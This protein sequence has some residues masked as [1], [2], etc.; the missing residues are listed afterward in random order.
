[1]TV[2]KTMQEIRAEF[3]AC[4]QRTESVASFR[5]RPAQQ[6]SFLPGQFVHVIFD[7]KDQTNRTLNKYLSFSCAPG[8]DFIEVT[9]RISTSAFSQRLLA[10]KAHDSILLRGPMGHCVFN[11]RY[12][13]VGFIIGGIGITPIISIIEYIVAHKLVTDVCVL[14]SNRFAHDIPFKSELDAWQKQCSSLKVVYSVVD[15]DPFD[16]HCLKGM[17]DT[18]MVTQYMPEW[19]DRELFIF[20]PPVMV[21]AMNALCSELVCDQT[22]LHKETFVGY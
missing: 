15:S 12:Q 16:A 13:K 18:H 1:M 2:E 20:G 3:I 21:N 19:Q 4:I 6:F 11:E 8:K 10:L 22:K 7:E 14:Y 17:I 5:F 9:K